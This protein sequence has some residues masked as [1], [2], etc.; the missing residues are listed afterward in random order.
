MPVQ[1]QSEMTAALAV[2][3]LSEELK[4][5]L[6][7]M[8]VLDVLVGLTVSS[9]VDVQGNSAAAIGNLSSKGQFNPRW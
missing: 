1:V 8:Q 5:R 9:S 2:L 4:P 6:L 7:A 3:A